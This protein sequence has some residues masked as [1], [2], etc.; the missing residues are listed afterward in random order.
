MMKSPENKIR[1][2]IAKIDDLVVK[3]AHNTDD[4]LLFC[5]SMVS[6][7]RNIYIT[8][9]G[10]EQTNIIF[11]QLAASFQMMEDFYPDETP[12]IH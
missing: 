10:V 8:T 1:H 6:V 11:E 2:F 4:K 3:E 12:T 9:L 7:V 5:A